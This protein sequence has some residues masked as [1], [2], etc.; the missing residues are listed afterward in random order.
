MSYRSQ[1]HTQHSLIKPPNLFF[2]KKSRQKNCTWIDVSCLK[3]RTTEH[4]IKILL[5]QLQLDIRACWITRPVFIMTALCQTACPTLWCV[6][7]YSYKAAPVLAWKQHNNLFG[8]IL[9]RYFALLSNSGSTCSTSCNI[10]TLE[11][12]QFISVSNQWCKHKSQ[13]K[14]RHHGHRSWLRPSYQHAGCPVLEQCPPPHC[15]S[16]VGLQDER[17][18]QTFPWPVFILVSCWT[19]LWHACTTC[20]SQPVITAQ[21]Q[22]ALMERNICCQ[23]QQ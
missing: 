13:C 15:Q 17:H 21:L 6:S 9:T 23:A 20:S 11:L 12:V 3:T 10:Y 7:E 1:T 5:I 22:A 8:N 14:H 4:N 19:G 18:I 16:T 2:K